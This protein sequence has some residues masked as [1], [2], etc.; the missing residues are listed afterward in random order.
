MKKFLLLTVFCTVSMLSFADSWID[1]SWKRML[2]ESDVV[3]I[4]EYTSEGAFRGKA[5]IINIYKGMLKSGDEISI[6]GFSNKF[7]PIDTVRIG[8]RFLVF[9]KLNEPDKYGL[10]WWREDVKKDPTLKEFADLYT[11]RKAYRVWSP[12]SGDLKIKSD[13]LQYDLVQTTFYTNQGHHVISEFEDFLQAYYNA[14]KRESFINKLII[15]LSPF[16][17]SRNR[18][19]YL[20]MLKFLGYDQYKPIFQPYALATNPFLRYATAQLLGGMKDGE[21]RQLLVSMI[22]DSIGFVQGEA[23]RQLERQPADFLGPILIANLKQAVPG[24]Y[25]P[26]DIMNPVRNTIDGGKTQ[27]IETLGNIGYKGAIPA[28]LPMLETKDSRDF[29]LVVYTLRK[30]GTREYADYINK[31]LRN[32]EYDML[33]DL[34]FI[35]DEDSLTQCIPSLIYFVENHDRLKWPTHDITISQYFGLGKFWTDPKVMNFLLSDFQKLNT[36]VPTSEQLS[37]KKQWVESYLEMFTEWSIKEAKPTA[38]DL[39]YDYWG[40]NLAFKTNPELFQQKRQKEDSIKRFIQGKVGDGISSI[41][42]VVYL[43]VHGKVKD[44]TAVMELKKESAE[45]TMG[46]LKA[47]NLDDSHIILEL[48]DVTYGPR[49]QESLASMIDFL[50]YF[51]HVADKSDIAFLRNLKSYGYARSDYEIERLESFLLLA[52]NKKK[53]ERKNRD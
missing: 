48:E 23:V 1:P 42:V 52:T 21:S 12:T 37:S 31:H 44:Y 35:I 34:C 36:L 9:I 38:Y 53:W 11:N 18:I 25:G 17:E 6:S 43:D 27:I 47:M 46:T 32:L 13:S 45:Q 24:D 26:S 15:Q 8:D 40:I 33:L 2:D 49:T 4:I 19:Q 3:A 28:L 39:M 29:K 30:L 16:A 50:Y 22:R 51:A 41:N 5:K 7:G 10:K 20:F 14:A